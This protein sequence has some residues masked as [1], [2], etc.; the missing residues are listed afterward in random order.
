M[1]K[2]KEKLP[3]KRLETRREP[4]KGKKRRET[5]C[6][7]KGRRRRRKRKKGNCLIESF[8]GPLF[9]STFKD[10]LQGVLWVVWVERKEREKL[11]KKKN[12]GGKLLPLPSSYALSRE[13]FKSATNQSYNFDN[14]FNEARSI[15]LPFLML[16]KPLDLKSI[17]KAVSNEN[18]GK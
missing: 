11:K 17:C 16:R 13:S 6:L 7:R 14:F 3:K 10:F 15:R 1:Q 5:I 18:P 2:K 9:S 8:G 12:L 4:E